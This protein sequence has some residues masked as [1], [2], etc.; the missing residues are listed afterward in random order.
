[1]PDQCLLLATLYS[2][3]I[4]CLKTPLFVVAQTCLGLTWLKTLKTG[5][6]TKKIQVFEWNPRAKI[7]FVVL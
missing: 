4:C 3:S 7:H 2:Y 6:L 1:M 5:F